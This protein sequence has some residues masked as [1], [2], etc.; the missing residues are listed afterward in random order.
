MAGSTGLEPAASG[1]TGQCCN[2]TQLR[3][4]TGN[5]WAIQGSNLWPTACK[6]AALPAELIAQ[7]TVFIRYIL[8]QLL[9]ILWNFI[10]VRFQWGFHYWFFTFSRSKQSKRFRHIQIVFFEIMLARCRWRW[11]TRTFLDELKL[12]TQFQ[13]FSN[14]AWSQNMSR[15]RNII[16]EKVNTPPHGFR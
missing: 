16:A 10:R 3:P 8:L 6:A 14:S 5:W 11:M 9:R 1:V 15:F 12:S 13:H 7:S 4:H 2:Q